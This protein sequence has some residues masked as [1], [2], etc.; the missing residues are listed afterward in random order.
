MAARKRLA[1]VGTEQ[2]GPVV[3]RGQPSACVVH[4]ATRLA[5][6]VKAKSMPKF[7]DRYAGETTPGDGIGRRT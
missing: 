4:E 3:D 6:M 7:V 1:A 5:T 2:A